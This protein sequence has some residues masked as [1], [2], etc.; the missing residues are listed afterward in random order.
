[1]RRRGVPVNVPVYVEPMHF[2]A[3]VQAFSRG[4]FEV[5]AR[6]V[7]AQRIAERRCLAPPPRGPR[8]AN[9]SEEDRGK[10]V[11]RA[12]LRAKRRV[13]HSC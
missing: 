12:R 5:T 7:D 9:S 13:R 1:M 6:L 3:S 2:M 11:L 4:G 10:N 8:L